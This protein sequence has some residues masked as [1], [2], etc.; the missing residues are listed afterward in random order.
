ME[1]IKWPGLKGN[2]EEDFLLFPLDQQT[3]TDEMPGDFNLVFTEGWIEGKAAAVL[4]GGGNA[5][6]V[7][8]LL[9]RSGI[10]EINIYH[11][12]EKIAQFEDIF[13]QTVVERAHELFESVNISWRRES[14]MADLL[15]NLD[16]RYNM[17]FMGSPLCE[18]EILPFYQEIKPSFTGSIT[19]VRS[20]LEEIG[21]E[22][23]NPLYR[24]MRERT[25]DSSEFS[26]VA[27]LRAMKKKLDKR[28]C[29]VLPTLNEQDTVGSVIQCALEVRKL[30]LIDEVI[31][32]DSMSS[33]QTVQVVSAFG[34]PVF[35][36]QDIHPELGSFKGKGEAMFKSAFVTQADIIA[37][38]DTDISTI[39]PK[40]FYG[41]LGPLLSNPE[42]RFSK[43]YF[44]RP[45]RIE[46]SGIELGGGRV[47]ELLA[48]PWINVFMPELAPFI[49]PLAGTV[50]IYREDFMRMRIPVS[51]GVEIAMLIQEVRQAGMRATCQVN[52]GEVVHRSKDMGGLSDMAFQILQTLAEIYHEL[53]SEKVGKVARSIFSSGGQF[54]LV[55]KRFDCVWREY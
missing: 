38:V 42:I 24:W 21:F 6:A 7:L 26:I 47:T 12:E 48:K 15:A 25:F 36:H 10:K 52:L 34:V 50:A 16:G 53:P 51:Y 29:V 4:R 54:Q 49:Q 1:K 11:L 41:L 35:V 55:A 13:T 14:C 22:D 19:I 33:D 39:T 3:Q 43:G 45:V 31:V 8:E 20:R 37:W 9:Q 40:F 17:V 44:S 27:T 46:T 28:I 23:N 32:V 30:G 18:S 2:E 5:I